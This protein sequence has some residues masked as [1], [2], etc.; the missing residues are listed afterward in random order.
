MVPN[1]ATH[2]ICI[3]EFE[4][5]RSSRNLTFGSHKNH[6]AK[7]V[8]FKRLR[9]LF[10]AIVKKGVKKGEDYIDPSYSSFP[11]KVL[12]IDHAFFVFFVLFVLLVITASM[13]PSRHL[14]VQS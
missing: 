5:K 12:P 14:H 10:G 13:L 7:N 8:S 4:K 11:N 2:H 9:E 3:S 6:N 1:R